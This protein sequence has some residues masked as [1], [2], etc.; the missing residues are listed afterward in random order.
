[1]CI[2]GSMMKK[3]NVN[4]WESMLL[5]KDPLVKVFV[6]SRQLEVDGKRWRVVLRRELG[7]DDKLNDFEIGKWKAIVSWT[8]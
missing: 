5:V 4:A 1:M 8:E 3:K 6:L 2:E 7:I